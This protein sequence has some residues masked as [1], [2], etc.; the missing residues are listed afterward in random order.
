MTGTRESRSGGLPTADAAML[1][2][3]P[4]G[5]RSRG[6]VANLQRIDT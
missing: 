1:F 5:R 2:R 4:G 6:A 3:R